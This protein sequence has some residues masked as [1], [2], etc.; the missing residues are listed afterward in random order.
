MITTLLIILGAILVLALAVL[1]S[2][3]MHAPEGYEDASGFHLAKETSATPVR[4]RA[5]KKRN[6]RAIVHGIDLHVPAA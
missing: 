6:E 2:N 3:T 5:L 4:R 1:V